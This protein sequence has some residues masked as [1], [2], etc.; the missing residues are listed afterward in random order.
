MALIRIQVRRG[1]KTEL[2]TLGSLLPGE[3]G[4]TTDEK[5]LYV[6]DG[7]DDRNF[8][9]GRVAMGP[10]QPSGA[11]VA[12]ALYI[13]VTN[14]QLHYCDGTEWMSVGLTDIE[15]GQKE[16]LVGTVEE[17]S[18]VNPYV[19]HRDLETMA[20]EV[21]ADLLDLNYQAMAYTPQNTPD[22]N[23]TTQLSAHLAGIDA[24]LQAMQARLDAIES[25]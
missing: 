12:G 21:R 10:G 19:T 2:E 22:A 15:T 7:T 4:F 24:A 17:P 23:N 9:V 14:Q 18:V 1:T 11:I 5:R 6:G 25:T 8:L 3:L 13:D 16:A 20:I